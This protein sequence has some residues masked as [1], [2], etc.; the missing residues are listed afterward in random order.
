[1]HLEL[2]PL[3]LVIS[4][5]AG[6]VLFAGLLPAD[7]PPQTDE[8]DPPP[9][10]G[11]ALRSVQTSVKELYGSYK[12]TD[13]GD[14]WQV[15]RRATDVT[16]SGGLAFNAVDAR[17]TKLAAVKITSPADGEVS[18]SIIPLAAVPTGKRL[19]VSIGARCDDADRFLGF[20]GQ[21]RDVEHHGSTVP[22]FVSEP[23]VGKKDD[24]TQDDIF[25]VAGTRHASEF[26]APIYLANRG[27]V[28]ALDGPGR[29]LFAMC[30]ETDAGGKVLRIAQDA[31]TSAGNT[32]A[33]RLFLG[34]PTVALGRSTARYGKPRI[35]PRLAF[36][37][38]NDAIFGSASVRAEL[39]NLRAKDIPSSAIW[40]EDFRGGDFKG[41]D[42]R[43]KENWLVDRSLY[44]D[45]EKLTDDLHAK[46]FAFFLYYN[47]FVEQNN[48]VWAQATSKHLLAQKVDGSDYIFTNAKQVPAGMLDLTNPDARAFM[49]GVLTDV[50]AYGVDGW[51]G[52]F[53]EW[54]PVDGKMSDGSD[55]W[56][57]HQLYPKAWQEVQRAALDVDAIGV[58][59]SPKERRLSFVRSG[60]LGSA[61]LAD[62]VWGGDQRSDMEP[63]DGLPTVVPMGLGLGIAGI[64]TFTHDVGGY[65]SATNEPTSK[66]TFFRWTELGAFTPVMRTHHGTQP[67]KEWRWDRDDETIA[68]YRRY[69]ILHQQ[70]LPM[71][72]LLAKGANTTG[73]PIWRHLALMFPDE[74][75]A[76]M[77]GDEFLVGPSILVAPV[78]RKGIILRE[79]YFPRGTWFP[80][81]GGNSLVGGKSF[82]VEAL[83]GE[84]PV[85]VH[86]GAIIP[87]LPASVRTVLTDIAGVVSAADVKDDRV[88]LV[89]AGPDVDVQEVSGL[90]YAQKGAKSLVL[91]DASV[92]WNGAALAS[93]AS[94]AVAPCA[95]VVKGRVLATVIGA[96]TLAAGSASVTVTGGEATRALTLDWRAPG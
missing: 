22:L 50:L 8:T 54:L 3:R 52:D 61:P 77:T 75:Q 25:F 80:F 20:G 95:T 26:P 48:D 14:P 12:I 23:G 76:W 21:Q 2:D 86:E 60:W 29:S 58:K 9:L 18:V 27:Y 51:M 7:V 90:S 17:G 13:A 82:G 68:H 35:P 46:G 89:T 47:T 43:L 85:Y 38:W 92:T 81:S 73:V 96:G 57:A 84:I 88:I 87:M 30:S 69:A 45:I 31:S 65:Q 11:I 49:T 94:P 10:T 53:G 1:M 6:K 70:L 42:Y 16:T 44:P 32:F 62:V 24:D 59:A 67:N 40:T 15:A 78:T 39:A 93:C 63:D 33:Y 4:D 91:E 74:A 37:P 71:W 28:G 55:P 36:A 79:V 56:A 5:A 34:T 41:D 19:W 83:L 66:E 64:S 72:E